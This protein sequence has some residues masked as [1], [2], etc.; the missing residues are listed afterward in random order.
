MIAMHTKC[1]TRPRREY[2]R[3]IIFF[4]WDK[5]HFSWVYSKSFDSYLVLFSQVQETT[6]GTVGKPGEHPVPNIGKNRV[7]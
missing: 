4:E 1:T 5:L 6:V 3:I 7:A 2:D